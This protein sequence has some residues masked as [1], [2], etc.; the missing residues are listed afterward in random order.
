MINR[1]PKSYLMP[2]PNGEKAHA[3]AAHTNSFWQRSIE[4]A[5]KCIGDYPLA[6]IGTAFLVGLVVGRVIKR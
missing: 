1:L 2:A 4:G 6:A 5:A 3:R